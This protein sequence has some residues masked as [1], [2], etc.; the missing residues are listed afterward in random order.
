MRV[1]L[2]MRG[3]FRKWALQSTPRKYAPAYRRSF[4]LSTATCASVSPLVACI[5]VANQMVAD[6]VVKQVSRQAP[7]RVRINASKERVSSEYEQK[8]ERRTYEM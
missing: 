7:I 2:Q 8:R 6:A 1:G 3:K 4:E 5:H